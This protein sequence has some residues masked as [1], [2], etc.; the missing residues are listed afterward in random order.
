MLVRNSEQVP[1]ATS[2]LASVTTSFSIPVDDYDIFSIQITGTWVGTV[3]FQGSLD[4]SNWFPITMHNIDGTVTPAATIA[5]AGT[6]VNGVYNKQT[7]AGLLYFRL[8]MTAY[9]S[10]TLAHRMSFHRIGR[11]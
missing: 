9:T 4:N 3:T 2:G 8:N 11:G 1:N 6:N 10:G 7:G 5:S